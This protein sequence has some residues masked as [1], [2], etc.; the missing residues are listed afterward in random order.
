M[1]TL[2]KS[3]APVKNK[4]FS[5]PTVILLTLFMAYWSYFFIVVRSSGLQKLAA[6]GIFIGVVV[7]YFLLLYTGEVS[8]YRRILFVSIALLFFP[9]FIGELLE[10]RGSMMLSAAD[11]FKNE[12]PYCH[13]VT[14]MALIPYALTGT[15][16]FPANT[17]WI[18]RI[19]IIWLVATFTI[20][21]GW[22]SWACFYGGWDEGISSLPKKI[23]L[24]IDHKNDKIRYFGF[25][26]LAFVVLASLSVLVPVYCEWLC[27]FKLVTEFDEVNSLRS[28]AAFILFVLLF[29]ALVV[30]LPFLTKKR[31]QCMSFCPMGGLQSLLNKFNLYRVRID[32]DKCIQCLVCVK[33]CPT[34]SLKEEAIKEKKSQ[35]LITCTR[36]GQCMSVCPKGAINYSFVFQGKHQHQQSI[37]MNWYNRLDRKKGI[38]STA[39]KPVIFTIHEL[40]SARALFTFSGFF[41]GMVFLSAFGTGTLHRFLNLVVNG[42]FLLE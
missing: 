15:I 13:I 26:M 27:P 5:L 29:F 28:Y 36:C 24:K 7:V 11:M 42:S 19:L 33:T 23:R 2:E 39:L 38:I 20:G 40:L 3:K 14:S 34:L 25:V 17:W 41:I 30:V 8:R 4:A 1:M 37:W 21:R 35:P 12:T 16:I 32:K 10:A 6:W 31:F 9:E 18:Y 22:C